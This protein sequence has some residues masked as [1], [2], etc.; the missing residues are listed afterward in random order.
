MALVYLGLGTNLGERADNLR[1]AIA[2]LA[3]LGRVVA[4]SGV[5]ETAP[6]Y[7]TDQPAFLNMAVAFETEWA[8]RDLLAQLKTLE[9]ELGRVASIRFG[10]RLIDLD[11]LIY[12]GVVMDDEILT[13]PHPRLGERRFALAPL[14]DIA[15]DL[16]HPVCGLSVAAM[17]AALPAGDDIRFVGRLAPAAPE[18]L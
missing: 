18:A 11:I 9:S 3:R 16:R 12:A 4:T 2:A 1:A 8:P 14:A 5:W 17:L 7:V 15:A 13:L 6:L 10:P